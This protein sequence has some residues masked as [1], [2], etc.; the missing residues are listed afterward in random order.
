MKK[1]ILLILLITQT[2]LCFTQI[3]KLKEFDFDLSNLNED[4]QYHFSK[5]DTIYYPEYDYHLVYIYRT[6]V[7]ASENRLLFLFV[8]STTPLGTVENYLGA[9]APADTRY[10][11]FYKDSL[12]WSEFKSCSL[13][14]VY[15]FEKD[16]SL[17]IT[18]NDFWAE[19]NQHI[20][21]D[22]NLNPLDTLSLDSKIYPLSSDNILI[23]DDNYSGASLK[24][25]I[26]SST[27][28]W[29]KHYT[30]SKKYELNIS[31]SGNRSFY[32]IQH[33][34]SI[35]SYNADHELI[36]GESKAEYKH[37]PW[38][39]FSGKYL[40]YS[41]YE[42]IDGTIVPTILIFDNKNCKQ[43]ASIDSVYYNNS[44]QVL[45]SPKQIK[46]SDFLFFRNPNWDNDGGD[47]VVTDILGRVILY[48]TYTLNDFPTSIIKLNDEFDIYH[49]DDLLE[50][51]KYKP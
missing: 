41:N 27:E 48:K 2:L 1:L 17:I 49:N 21:Y 44:Y 28:S 50:K 30:L 3:I 43:L 16:S 40:L 31:C 38:F 5:W 7:Y 33:N 18:W 20:F 29:I 24:C 15:I 47:L 9:D 51:I 8:E 4:N 32:S 14:E 36:W 6:S 26:N 39:T 42:I 46:Y 12:L 25:M 22:K 34:D 10:S 45:H 37:S 23:R 13:D 11:Y 35:K 19:E